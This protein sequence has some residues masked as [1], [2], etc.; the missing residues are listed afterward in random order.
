MITRQ[1]NRY[2]KIAVSGSVDLAE[3]KFED[4]FLN[5]LRS[6]L[7][8]VEYVRANPKIMYV[9]DGAFVLRVARGYEDGVVLAVS[10][11]KDVAGRRLGFYT[12]GIS[13]AVGKLKGK[14]N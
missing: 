6:E 12:L 9:D 11:V 7:G 2:I 3:R 8:S 5:A 10:F 4:A 14:K 13:G 1:K